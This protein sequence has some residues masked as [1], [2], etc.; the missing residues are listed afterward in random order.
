MGLGR[1]VS[2]VTF[3]A[4]AAAVSAPGS[5][6]QRQVL[7][8]VAVL[9]LG[10]LQLRAGVAKRPDVLVALVQDLLAD[11]LRIGL[12]GLCAVASPFFWSN[13]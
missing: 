4:G 9:A 12:V 8:G 3:G 2:A 5:G 7:E 10:T 11:Q 6:K 1:M 13:W